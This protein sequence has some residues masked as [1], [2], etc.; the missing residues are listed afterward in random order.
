MSDKDIGFADGTGDVVYL[1]ALAGAL[2]A[3]FTD[4]APQLIIYLAGAD[5]HEGDR[6]G[7]LKLTF[8]G[9]ARRDQMVLERARD[10]RVPV[11]ITMAGGYGTDIDSTIAVHLKTIAIAADHAAQWRMRYTTTTLPA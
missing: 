3:V 5:P 6:L 7:K 11:A 2:D 10:H 8:D 4:F 9:L 1:D